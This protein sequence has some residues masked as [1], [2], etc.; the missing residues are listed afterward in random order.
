MVLLCQMRDENVVLRGEKRVRSELTS[1][2]LTA[3]SANPAN[4]ESAKVV[5]YTVAFPEVKT[6]TSSQVVKKLTEENKL[7]KRRKQKKMFSL[8]ELREQLLS[9]DDEDLEFGKLGFIEVP[10]DSPIPEEIRGIGTWN[11]VIVPRYMTDN[12]KKGFLLEPATLV[13]QESI[14]LDEII[15]NTLR[16]L[17]ELGLGERFSYDSKNSTFTT[18]VQL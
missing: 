9:V 10:A 17:N 2:N 8:P 13:G 16:K 3:L 7:I 14:S 6:M 4:L 5:I 12:E 15:R 18:A 1:A 11:G